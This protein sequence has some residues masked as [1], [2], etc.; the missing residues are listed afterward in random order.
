V[1]TLFL[2]CAIVGGAILAIQTVLGLVGLEHEIELPGLHDADVPGDALNLLSVRALAAGVLFFGLAGLLAG[3]SWIALAVALAAGFAATL[4]VAMATRAM[5]RM[6]SDGSVQMNRAVG[7]T[8]QVYLGIPA[9]R[10]APGKVHLTVQGR[11]VE[12]Q[13]VSEHA[14]ASG[15]SVL[16]VDVVGPD[17]VEVIPSPF[18]GVTD[19]TRG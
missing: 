4:A 13:A 14:L 12:C 16:V 19:G 6:E 15:S 8:G 2:V 11:T 1:G 18:D 5:M 10:A 3:G 9:G 17:L 7:Q